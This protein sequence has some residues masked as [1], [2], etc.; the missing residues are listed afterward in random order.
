MLSKERVVQS[1]QNEERGPIK[2]ASAQTDHGV[3][4]KR[5][6]HVKEKQCYI[7]F[8]V[9][10]NTSQVNEQQ[11]FY[12]FLYIYYSNL[13]YCL[14][15]EKEKKSHLEEKTA[16]SLRDFNGK[17]TNLFSLLYF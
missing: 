2:D 8:D 12:F 11:C 16:K 7:P 1:V 9:I 6:E 10:N 13:R 5:K 4:W 17:A 14:K 3:F 15:K